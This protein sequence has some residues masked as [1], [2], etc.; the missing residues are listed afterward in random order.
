MCNEYHKNKYYNLGVLKYFQLKILMK[1]DF[2]ASILAYGI[3][4]IKSIYSSHFN[5]NIRSILNLCKFGDFFLFFLPEICHW[6]SF[7]DF[8]FVLSHCLK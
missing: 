2:K 6:N 7:N 4:R 3:Q 5:F 8:S 1:N